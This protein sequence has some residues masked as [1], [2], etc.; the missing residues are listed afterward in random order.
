M[1][2]ELYKFFY[3]VARF[4]NISKA[5]EQLFVTQPAVSRAVKQLEESLGCQLFFRNSKGVQLTQEGEVLYKHIDQAFNFISSG[6]KKIAYF[7]NLQQG[8]IRIGASDTLCKYYLVPYLKL[9]KTNFPAIKVN[10]TCPTTPEIIKLLKAGKIDFGIVNM[11]VQDE[12]LSFKN[13]MKIQDCFIAGQ[14]Y[15]HLSGSKRH[16][17]EI[18]EYP[19]LL[20]EK[21]SNSRVYVDQY[22]KHNSISV[23]PDFEFPNIDLLIHFAKYDFGIACVIEN[24]IDEILDKSSLYKI[25]LIENIPPRSMSAAWLTNT[26]LTAA[27]IELLKY[28]E[29]NESYEI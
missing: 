3:F 12:Q 18:A 17:S 29:Y 2:L 16:I 8:E 28:L 24:F 9:F 11:P 7:K 14:K 27:A 5:S 21:A 10:V 19:M 22:F 26:P 6:E 4:G 25:N 23:T 15:K 13:I 1:N 20:L